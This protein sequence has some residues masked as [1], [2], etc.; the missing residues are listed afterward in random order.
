VR[1]R[2]VT[3][4]VWKGAALGVVTLVAF[5]VVYGLLSFSYGETASMSASR[6]EHLETF[7][8][9][10]RILLMALLPSALVGGL[11]GALAR[12]LRKARTLKLSAAA[13][14][15]YFVVMAAT[16]AIPSTE[17]LTSAWFGILM[18][19]VFTPLLAPFA[20]VAA[21]IIE[22]WTRPDVNAGRNDAIC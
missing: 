3:S 17:P 16:F 13:V 6:T 20:L 12:G 1:P 2:R 19:V 4:E 7:K 11:L 21:V 18:G 5:L 22:R 8:F 10:G 15:G 9:L 14:L